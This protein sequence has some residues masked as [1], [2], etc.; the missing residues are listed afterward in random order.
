MRARDEFKAQTKKTLAERAGY[1]CSNPSCRALTAGPEA[2]ESGSVNVGIA[3]HITAAAGGGARF[4]STL[5]TEERCGIDNGIWLCT[6]CATLI[7]KQEKDYSVQLL[8]EWKRHSEAAARR[9][10]ERPHHFASG[11]SNAYTI[12]IVLRYTHPS[13]HFEISKWKALP[14]KSF[15]QPVTFRPLGGPKDFAVNAPRL[16]VLLDS[17]LGPSSAACAFSLTLEN[18]G[19]AIESHAFISI[20]LDGAVIWKQN[21]QSPD[22]MR[23]LGTPSARALSSIAGFSVSDLM[24]GECF[25][26]TVYCH[27]PGPFNA[28]AFCSS[29]ASAVTPMVFDVIF[30]EPQL[31]DTP[32]TDKEF[33]KGHYPFA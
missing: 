3:A 28:E 7:D 25:G 30:G 17:S 27:K 20:R 19:T 32:P 6:R 11:E 22:R 13:R 12:A 31:G 1:H 24:P 9:G 15:Y 10:I 4:D 16:C 8:R 2:N 14:G 33:I 5:S 18:K 29:V 23:A 21:L 26:S